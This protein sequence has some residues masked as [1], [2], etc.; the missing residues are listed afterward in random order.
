MG[1]SL[2]KR[3]RFTDAVGATLRG[4]SRTIDQINPLDNGRTWKQ[5]TPTNNR[6][7]V[8]QATHNAFTNTAGNIAKPFAQ[9]L[10]ATVVEPTRASVAFATGNKRAYE[11]ADA[12]GR[13]AFN[14]SLPA[15]T[16]RGAVDIAN[17]PVQLTKQSIADVTGNK[18]ASRN[19]QDK[20]FQSMNRTPFGMATNL[21][22]QQAAERQ[23]K[24]DAPTM[25]KEDQKKAIVKSKESVGLDPNASLGKQLIE[26]AAGTAT[27]VG[28]V[29]TP[30]SFTKAAKDSLTKPK[31]PF[32]I[33]EGVPTVTPKQ[34]LKIKAGVPLARD[35]R[36]PLPK[37]GLKIVDNSI[38]GRP[39]LKIKNLSGGPLERTKLSG[40]AEQANLSKIA[41]AERRMVSDYFEGKPV[42]KG[43]ALSGEG[44]QL[45][46]K[47]NL[48]P[49]A[50]T[51]MI[52]E[53]RAK[54]ESTIA[55]HGSTNDRLTS[56][57]P[58][59][60]TGLNEKRNLIYLAEDKKTATNYAKT[61]GNGSDGLGVLQKS[62][63]GRVYGVQ[64]RGKVLGAYDFDQLNKMKQAP[65]FDK[66]SGKTR[67]QL[68]SPTGLS[69]DI[70]ETN[71]ELTKFLS[72]N[73]VSA[74]RAHLIN[75]GGNE[76]IVVNP[77]NIQMGGA[78][79]V[80]KPKVS[81][82]DRI[83]NSTLL[84]D[85]GGG[86]G[87]G[88]TAAERIAARNGKKTA[89]DA[90]E[91]KVEP[92][93]NQTTKITSLRE[94]LSPDRQIRE[95]ITRPLVEGVNKGIYK[96]SVSENPIARGTARLVQGMG[97]EIGTPQ[98]LLD[99]RR[100]LF[101]GQEYAKLEGLNT[102]KIGKDL[103]SDKLSRVWA[104]LDQEQ[105]AKAGIKIDPTD[106]T[107]EESVVRTQLAK[108]VD[109]TTD[110][111]LSR[112]LITPEQAANPSYLK[113][114]YE[115]FELAED[116]S[117]YKQVKEG[118]L[119]QYKGRKD[120]NGDL[121]EK[122][123]QDPAYLVGK[124]QAQSAQAW[125]HVDYANYLDDNGFTF[126][127]PRKGLVQLPENK[128]YGKASGKWVAP[129]IA[130]DFKGFQY[131]NAALNAYNDL[132]TAYDSL[133]IRQG[134]KQLLTVFNP[135]VRL[136]NQLSNRVAFS[137]L[138]GHN[139]LEFNAMMQKTKGMIKN[140]DPLYKEAVKEGIIGTDITQAEF[141]KNLAQYIDDPNVLK[142]AN[143]WVKSSY[144]Q[145][146]DRARLSSYALHRKQGY[147]P[148][149]A[150]R[151]TQRGFQ[152]YK[153]VGFFFD[154]AAK[155]PV[156]GNAFVRFSGDANRIIAN[157]LIDHPLRTASVVA[158]YGAMNNAMSK[159]S[160]ESE[161]DR[162]TREGR[163]GAPK[164]PFTDV[165]LTTQTPW[166]EVNVARFMPFYQLNDVQ[167]T[168]NRS[169]PIQANPLKS[170]GWNDPIL[171]Q[172]LQIVTDQDFRGKSIRDPLNTTYD[173]KGNVKKFPD[174]QQGD[175]N[176]NLAR[177]L[178]TQNAPLGREQDALYSA[179]KGQEDIYGKKRS[180]PQAAARS[181][182]F[183]VEQFGAKEAEKQ[184][185]SEAY[186][187]GNIE[188]IKKFNKD[189]PDLEQAYYTF[190]SPTR[191]RKTGK[192]TSDLVSPER[193]KVV[194]ADKSGRLYN[195]LS[196]EAKL[197]NQK[198][199]KPIDPVFNLPTPEQQKQVLELRSRPTGDDIETE[200]ILR[201]TQPWYKEFE[202]AE[203]QYYKDNS[204]YYD[205]LGLKDTQNARVKE[206]GSIKYP[207]QSSLVQQ[208][209]QTKASNPE[210]GKAFFKSHADALSADFNTYKQ[211][212]L[213]YI[214]AK[215]KIEGFPPISAQAFNNV[216]F[217]YEDDERKVFNELKYS[218]GYGGYGSGGNSSIGVARF[219]ADGKYTPSKAKIAFKGAP[220][221]AVKQRSTSAGK[222]KVSI[223][224]SLV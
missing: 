184:R 201:A 52:A 119:K 41:A 46:S 8:G 27:L 24:R 213:Q 92:N 91:G 166:G 145:A 174:L 102:T 139:P 169:L 13:Q 50:R 93:L 95:K 79:T 164:I 117:V 197:A 159:I 22:Q 4:A 109:E 127:A 182:G 178:Y 180:L 7:V 123:I 205:K 147:S 60:K 58:G 135:A 66:L 125:A 128:L 12:R 99:A 134:K 54:A 101:G 146:D 126:S 78:D 28:M 167:G 143:N 94:R 30:A 133:K 111:N 155:T 185:G 47:Q 96:A 163:F 1:L 89:L 49:E 114:A 31:K 20:F 153:S 104:T 183:K 124:K 14:A 199:G 69:A 160:G 112:G 120:V 222:P 75:G 157:S 173:S 211:Q 32:T 19:A 71:P 218:K 44:A 165:S 87:G 121:I 181:M 188:R 224:K 63:T 142:K 207:E 187:E 107:P 37:A 193:W 131:Q 168:W 90:L 97:R 53:Q 150:A 175:K 82:K 151:L 171:G 214:N 40:A 62:P 42:V 212:R 202:K 77:R 170:S 108:V 179:A 113:R 43:S 39:K 176:K 144:S 86:Y 98:E 64:V 72:E 56:L 80:T 223:K 217:G 200:E 130:E 33:N 35:P 140:Q 195:F 45:P 51:K 206:Y 149:D 158:L 2:P 29:K 186:F 36:T 221:I 38:E 156:I 6:S 118:L 17:M 209:Y 85:E 204:G 219:M 16:A 76:L 106:L 88:T 81:L 208:Y 115:P 162:A 137:T 5:R 138:N 220:K 55:Y 73:G 18:V 122:A 65:G 190:N 129:N 203:S 103:G 68:T 84:R 48:T 83:N 34:P 148:N 172:A 59:A 191:D 154:M 105:A 210:A 11:A 70:L 61:R 25:S 132:I 141:T 196:S 192:K 194:S 177:F 100:K 152:D 161:Q 9:T 110:G 57:Q 26:T 21:L 116:K 136:G 215:R 216:T 189:N 198:D 74:V 67:N 3:N 10:N 23:V 15:I